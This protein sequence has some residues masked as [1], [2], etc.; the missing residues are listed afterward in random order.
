MADIDALV[1]NAVKVLPEGELEQKLALGRPLRVKLGIDPTARDIHIGNAIPLQR[2][3]AFQQQGHVG[4]L[5]IGDYTARIGDPSGRSK[6]RR[7]LSDEEIDANARAYFEEASKIL[8]PDRTEL[9]FNSEWLGKLDFGELLRLTRTQTV[10]RLLERNDFERRF[11]ANQPISVSELLY[12]LM[13]GY[14][15]VATRADVELG[16]TDQEYNLLTARDIQQAYGVDPQV[17]LTTPLIQGPNGTQKMSASLGN[18]IGISEPP[19]EMYGKAMSS[20]DDLMP[21]YY[22]L[23]LESDTPP[24]ADPYQAKREYARRLVDRWHGAEAAAAAEAGFDRMFK[25]KR[26]TEDAPVLELPPADPVHLPALLADNGL[27]SSTSDARR[28]IKQGAVRVN[29]EPVH[30]LDTPAGAL[31]GKE[32]RVGRRFARIAG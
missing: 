28:L 30:A 6:E 23:T 3:R 31:R 21:E 12:P 26:A 24:P 13:Q 2:M 32:L 27:A 7:L 11:K 20:V 15:S 29:G 22:R 4:V 18:Y 16:G 10:S 1:R 25:E 17:V 19:V 8:D 14:D 9:L 5:I